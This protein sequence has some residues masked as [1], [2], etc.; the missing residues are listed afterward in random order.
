MGNP[1]GLGGGPTVTS[2]VVS[3]LNRTIQ[4]KDRIFRNL[5][6]TDAA[7]NP[8]NSGGPLIDTKGRVV[9]I[10]TATVPLCSTLGVFLRIVLPL[11]VPGIIAISTCS[12]SIAWDGFAFAITLLRSPSNWTAVAGIRTFIGQW[13]L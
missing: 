5:V 1:F 10:S 6:Q 9:T 12:F 3:A 4:S 7:I 11:S 13:M 2:G 8:G